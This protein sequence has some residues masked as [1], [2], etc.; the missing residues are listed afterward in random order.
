V[1]F[2]REHFAIPDTVKLTMSP[3]R[4][5]VFPN[6]NEATVTADDGK[7][8]KDQTVLVSRNDRYL[9]L[10]VGGEILD[11][12]GAGTPN[13]GAAGEK[14]PLFVRGHFKIPDAVKLTM[15]PLSSS[16]FPN[17][18]EATLTVDDG[19]RKTDWNLLISKDGR[20]LVLIAGEMFDLSMDMKR[21]ALKTI[22]THNQASQG[23]AKAPVTIVEY[24]D[25]ECPMCARIHEFFEKELLP[26][27]GDKVRLVFKELP[28]VSIH[29]WALAGAIASQ[30]IQ[31]INPEAFVPFRSLV[32]QNQSSLNA[33]N[34][35][36]ML[37]TYGEQVGVDRVRLAA[38]MD[39]KTS[40]PR[41]E[42]NESEAK[43]LEIISTP[44]CFINGKMIVAF[45]SPDTF[46]KAVDEALRGA[47]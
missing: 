12:A 19:K 25:L 27:Y 44:T 24:A 37:L 5:S 47:R 46:Y 32:Y 17:S 26:K 20:Y 33:A 6:A 39:A 29:E 21:E 3:L 23:P 10:V 11:L 4:S 28:L 8:K 30:C 13:I 1:S 9:I 2:L 38:C 14:V 18:K 36:D 45:P 7:Q 22:S 31:Q 40:L 34:S 35:R 16:V 43:H 41:V 42:E 15:S